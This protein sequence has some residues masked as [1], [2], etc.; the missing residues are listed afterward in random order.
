M[1]PGVCPE[2][3][4]ECLDVS[5]RRRPDRVGL[6]LA[7]ALA[8]SP[9]IVVSAMMPAS[10]AAI[11]WLSGGAPDG[12]PRIAHAAWTYAGVY[13][14]WLPCVLLPLPILLAIWRV[15]AWKGGARQFMMLVGISVG[16]G[17]VGWLVG[18]FMYVSFTGGV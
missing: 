16:G 14:K 6:W 11:D 3:G 12:D 5:G 7:G 17:V 4:T 1:D 8:L 9:I 10:D 13:F 15:R 18:A 2:C